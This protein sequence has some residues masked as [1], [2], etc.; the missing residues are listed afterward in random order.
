[1]Y[2]KDI[3]FERKWHEYIESKEGYARERAFDDEAERIFSKNYLI[4]MMIIQHF[5]IIQKKY[6][7]L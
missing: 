6:L 5:M 1:M 7:I 3:D 2:Y 4:N